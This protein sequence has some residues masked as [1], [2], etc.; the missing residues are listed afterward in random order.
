MKVKQDS[1][2]ITFTY[3]FNILINEPHD[4]DDNMRNNQIIETV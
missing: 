2:T 3:D 1:Q 4:I